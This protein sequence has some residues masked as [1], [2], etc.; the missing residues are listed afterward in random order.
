MAKGT[1][2]RHAISTGWMSTVTLA[3]IC[4]HLL[5]L[6][7]ELCARDAAITLLLHGVYAAFFHVP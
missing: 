4:V 1:Q 7:V 3:H 6:P 2:V 5:Y